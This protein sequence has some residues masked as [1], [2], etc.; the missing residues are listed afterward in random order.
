MT[1]CS[2]Q[3]LE[4]QRRPSERLQNKSKSVFVQGDRKTKHKMEVQSIVRHVE[5]S[6]I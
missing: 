5:S 4:V 1:Y 6:S 2:E 3:L